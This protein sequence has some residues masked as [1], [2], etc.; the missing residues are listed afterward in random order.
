VEGGRVWGCCLIGENNH[1]AIDESMVQRG[2][3][4]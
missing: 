2:T 3:H 4:G 1:G